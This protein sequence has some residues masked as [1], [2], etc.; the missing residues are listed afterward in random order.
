MIFKKV[1]KVGTGQEFS[2][3]AWVATILFGAIIIVFA[4]WGVRPDKYGDSA[5]GVAATVNDSSISL[6]EY[7]SRVENI[8]QNA[9]MRFDQFPE[10]QRKMLTQQ[11]RKRALEE[12]IWGELVYQA[13]LKQGVRASDGEVRETILEIPFLQENGRFMKDRYFM[14]LKN[15]NLTTE[16]FERQVRKQIVTQKVQE[17]FAASAAPT[18]EELKRSRLLA[19]QKV[20]VRFVEVSNEDLK[21]PGFMDAAEVQKFVKEK[22]SEIEKYYADN[23]I[24]FT[25][26]ERLK[27]RHL[28]V[29]IDDKRPDAEAKRLVEKIRS[30]ITTSNFAKLAADKSDDPGSKAKGGDLGEFGRGRMVPEFDKAAFALKEGEISQPVQSNFGYHLIYVEKKLPAATKA[31]KDVEA[32][33]ARKLL[34]Q[35]AQGQIVAKMRGLV[36]KGSKSEVDGFLGKAG[37]KWQESGEFDLSSPNIPKLGE[38]QAVLSAILRKGK[39]GG[40]INQLIDLGGRYV[41]LDVTSWKELPDKETDVEGLEKMV[42]YRKSSDL[43]ENWTKEV[44][45]KATIQRNPSLTQ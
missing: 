25:E 19:N 34:F 24:E 36:E 22:H 32:D 21:K 27:A 30:Q 38:N 12:L 7:R 9:R 3:K 4:L 23:K 16:G 17:L 45:A 15:M 5:G 33:I 29:R 31:L 11:L 26:E 43:F 40:L 37:V 44:E 1:G 10:A 20:N 39:S 2:L 35:S 8:E 13:A 41:I 42:A 6:A 18:R 14:F 28:L